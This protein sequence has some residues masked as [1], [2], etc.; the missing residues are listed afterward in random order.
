MDALLIL[1]LLVCLI[2]V[3]FI[4][5]GF[6][7]AVWVP[8]RTRDLSVL[9]KNLVLDKTSYV[10]EFG[11][12]DGRFLLAA[13]KRGATVVG[14]EINP[15]FWLIAVLRLARYRRGAAKLTNAWDESFQKATVVFAFLMPRFMTRLE[16]KFERELRPGTIVITYIFP[17]PGRKPYLVT[18]NC[19]FYKW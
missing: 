13:A 3:G 6:S 10:M 5:S 4:V 2:G 12:G 9:T 11:C 8:T 14:Y 16:A 7:G 1:L 17:L 18:N 15:L 19:Y